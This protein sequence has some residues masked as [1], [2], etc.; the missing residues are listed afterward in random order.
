MIKA[1]LFDLDGTLID[2]EK[3]YRVYWPKALEHFG[4]HMTD[5]QALSMRSF[6]APYGA[7]HLKEMFGPEI[8]YEKVRDYRR[9]IM[10]PVLEENGIEVKKG[11]AELLAHLRGQGIQTAVVTANSLHRTKELLDRCGLRK[12]FD[13]LISAKE[14]KRGKPAPDVY[15]YACEQLDLPPDACMAVEDSPNGVLSAYHA[16]CK[17]VMVPDQSEPDAE[18]MKLLYARVDG[19]EEI[20][21]LCR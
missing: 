20:R 1:V 17:V 7:Q 11:A 13:Y 2:T 5:E 21:A 10:E 19:L 6:G 14:T 12:Y 18:L 8:D 16:G 9:I 3:Y 4:Y 15:I